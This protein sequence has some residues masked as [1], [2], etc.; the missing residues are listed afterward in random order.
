MEF[1]T[2]SPR[3]AG[4]TSGGKYLPGTTFTPVPPPA[5]KQI[6]L[7]DDDPFFRGLFKVMLAQSGLPLASIAESE[8]AASGVSLCRQYPADIVFCDLN[9]SR[10]WPGNGIG[11][12]YDIRRIRPQ[13]PVYMVTADNESDV[14]E[15][16]FQSGAAG[17]L[18]KPLNLRVLKR[19]L[20]ATF[21]SRSF[22]V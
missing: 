21:R 14:I 19:V 9:L 22:D 10:L 1:P 2:V 7:I 13:L 6:L 4:R 15:K 16:V 3:D 11:V 18:L 17:H 20:M 12:V 5:G 8:D